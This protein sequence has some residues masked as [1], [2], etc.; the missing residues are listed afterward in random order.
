MP[1]RAATD[2]LFAD[3]RTIRTGDLLLANRY[4]RNFAFPTRFYAA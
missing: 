2:L 4:S 3:I 1:D